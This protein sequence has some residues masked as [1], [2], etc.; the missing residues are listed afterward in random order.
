MPSSAPTPITRKVVRRTTGLRK[1]VAISPFPLFSDEVPQAPISSVSPSPKAVQGSSPLSISKSDLVA[2]RAVPTAQH[3]F[4]PQWHLGSSSFATA[5]GAV[6][7]PTPK[8]TSIAWPG[9]FVSK[10]PTS[11]LRIR[12]SVS[13]IRLIPPTV[14]SYRCERRQQSSSFLIGPVIPS[15]TIIFGGAEGGRRVGVEASAEEGALTG[16]TPR[17]WCTAG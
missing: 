12:I 13:L 15:P 9:F 16:K 3:D 7:R 6:V 17:A 10:L 4:S 8:P 11:I 2:N 1:K 14:R 5:L